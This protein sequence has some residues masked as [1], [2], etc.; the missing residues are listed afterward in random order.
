MGRH[1]KE[2]QME[3]ENETRHSFNYVLDIFNQMFLKVTQKLND[4]LINL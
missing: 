1:G 3:I 2:N 4:S